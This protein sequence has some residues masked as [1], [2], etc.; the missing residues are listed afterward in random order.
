MS[1]LQAIENALF[2][3]N[4]TVFQELC[5]SFLAVRNSNY[6]AF[7]R[8]GSKSGKQKTIKGTPDTFLLLPNGKYIFVEHSTNITAGLSKLEDD[9][10]KCIDSAKTGI[11]TNRISEI[12]ICINFNLKSSEIQSLRNILVNTR[13][14]LTVN[15]LDSL[16]LELHLNHRD[17]THQYL[18]LAL[19][20]G[21]IVSVEKF[22][23]EY[24]SASK[25]ISTPLDNT[26][27]HRESELKE[28]KES[29]YTNDFI[30]LTG[31]PGIGKTKL[32]LE[33]IKSFLSENLSFT[34]YCIS[35]KN[36]TL[37]DDLFQYFNSEKDYLLLVDDANRIDAFNQITGFYK[38][39]RKGKIKIIITVRDYA[40]QE[41][42]ILCQEFSPKRIDINK[43][44]DEEIKS[45]IVAEPFKILNNTFK[46]KILSIA[47]GNPRLAIM[48]SLLAIAEQNIEKLYD[49]SD[50]FEKYYSTFINDDGEFANTLN[51]KCLGL[52]AFF[53]TIPYKNKEI[54]TS[55]LDNFEIGYTE[56][57]DVIDKLDKLELVEIQFEH[58]KIPEQNLSTY[59]FY[60]AFIKDNLLS[61]KTLLEK[62]Y[63]SNSDRFKDCVI[64][65]NNTFGHIK[66][67][68]MLKPELRNHWNAIKDGEGKAFQLLS[69]FWFYLQTE[70]LEFVFNIVDLLPVIN[71]DTYEVAYETNA[72]SYN[73]NKIIELLGEFFITTNNLKDAID[74]AFDYTRKIPEHL[75]ELI[76]KIRDKLTFDEK[77]QF[78]FLRQTILFDNLLEGLSKDDI[79]YSIVFFELSKT[80]LCYKFHHTKGVRNNTF[81]WYDYP[82]PNNKPIQEFREK[83]WKALESYY[84]KFPKE[85]FSLLQS[86]VDVHPDVI[87]EIMELD[88]VFVSRIIDTQLSTSSFEH[89]KYVHDQIK[90]CKRNSVNHPSFSKLSKKFTNSTYETFLKIDWD[91]LRDKE[92]YE[93]ENY[94]E[95]EKLKEIEIRTSFVFNSKKEID[96]FY[97]VFVYL[98][99]ISKNS[100]NYTSTL[101]IIVDENFKQD[102]EIGCQILTTIIENSNEIDYIPRMVLINHLISTEK[103]NRIWGIIQSNEFKDKHLWELSFH[104]T[105][106]YFLIDTKYIQALINTISNLN[107]TTVIHIE[108]FERFR[109]FEPNLFQILLTLIVDKNEKESFH[110]RL[111][112][113]FFSEHFDKLGDDIELIKKAYLQQ[114]RIQPRFDFNGKGL[115]N[116]LKVDSIFLVEYVDNLYSNDEFRNSGSHT[117]LSFV[118]QIPEIES[119]IE[120][121]FDLSVE[122]EQYLGILEHSANSF[123]HNLQNGSKEKAT[124]FL[125]N[126]SKIYH[127]DPK[128]MNI[129][130]DIT[131]HAMKE[132]FEDVLLQ[133]ISL[134]QNIEVFSRI[135]WRG[136]GSSGVGDI[137]LADIEAAD[138]RN[139][140]SIIEK[141]NIGIK[142]LPIKRY[143]SEKIESCLKSGDFERQR[144]FLERF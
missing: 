121:V 20:T 21:Q 129:V 110:L 109:A 25:G 53:Y 22:I 92:M 41:I 93:F 59:F 30:I 72:F 69:T 7:S 73:N 76:H 33:T 6:I 64:P 79:L 62:Y 28:L 82:I 26:F 103:A 52:I 14:L 50:L 12:I 45:I 58:V 127:S 107:E 131:R 80:F 102:Y 32:A 70:S 48:T 17:L 133:F 15:T 111:W 16:A 105:I 122:E 44:S 108:R 115:L 85:S 19:D 125:I 130:V 117:N 8:T 114:G 88:I 124:K 34:A 37:L 136:N 83:I 5:D 56:F 89:C 36:Y 46:E 23:A 113:G 95:Y 11:P 144:R 74:L 84:N 97:H 75:P 101:D 38:S 66:V 139:I 104:E 3:I 47:D 18:G 49:V 55:I 123:F 142:L 126:Y 27:L 60:K 9:V 128:R 100:W 57:I 132:L 137:I 67:M 42:G 91:R 13:I 77:D 120:K 138:W 106:K 24:N 140:L 40:F 141:S 68:D 61:F 10:K 96:D 94:K 2:S 1:R 4:E 99:N 43:F 119:I 112:M 118:W 51:I 78:L 98:K 31:A 87:K 134:N 71:N 116:I 86:Y 81:S 143:V 90:W 65:A 135:W 54:A 63:V 29:I 35:Y 39:G